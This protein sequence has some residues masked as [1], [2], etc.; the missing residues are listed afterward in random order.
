MSLFLSIW[1]VVRLSVIVSGVE[2]GVVGVVVEAE[3]SRTVGVA[4][5]VVAVGG[6]AVVIVLAL[7]GV[8]F[9][10]AAS[11]LPLLLVV[12]FVSAFFASALMCFAVEF[13]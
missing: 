10:R 3:A 8:D 7:V 13:H 1:L 9:R 12:S 5:D 6:I 11:L 4:G 2:L